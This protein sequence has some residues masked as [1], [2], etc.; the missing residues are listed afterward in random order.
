MEENQKNTGG[1]TVKRYY[2]TFK[3]SFDV[4]ADNEEDLYSHLNGMEIDGVSVSMIDITD[5]EDISMEEYM[6]DQIVDERK[7]EAYYG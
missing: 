7:L 6:A 3:G 1:N 5:K 4:V 2:G